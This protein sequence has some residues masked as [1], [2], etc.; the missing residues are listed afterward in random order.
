MYELKNLNNEFPG[1]RYVVVGS[2]EDYV[3]CPMTCT[4]SK[5]EANEMAAYWLGKYSDRCRILKTKIWVN[6]DCKEE[7]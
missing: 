4:N 6:I 3:W 1:V 5:K 7:A 2:G